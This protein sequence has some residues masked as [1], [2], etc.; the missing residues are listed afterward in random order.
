MT[1][2]LEAVLS[3]VTQSADAPAP[4]NWP[5]TKLAPQVIVRADSD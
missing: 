1:P 5:G 4:E 2:V 3:K